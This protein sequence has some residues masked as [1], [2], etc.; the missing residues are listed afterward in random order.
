MLSALL[1][2]SLAFSLHRDQ[3]RETGPVAILELLA[4][5]G[6]TRFAASNPTWRPELLVF[7][8]GDGAALAGLVLPAGGDAR[9]AFPRGTLDWL[10]V[11][12]F[13]RDAGVVRTTGELVLSELTQFDLLWVESVEGRLHAWGALP[14]G[15]VHVPASNAGPLGPVAPPPIAA[16]HVPVITPTDK[17]KG[18]LPPR[19][20]RKPLPPV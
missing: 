11:A 14:S 20:E 1:A 8:D 4:Q 16:P 6:E 5:V 17:P 3:D 15:F 13:T 12:L 19:I 7:F 10:G 18:D 2:T 9:F